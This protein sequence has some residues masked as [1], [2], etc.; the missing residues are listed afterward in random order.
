MTNTIKALIREHSIEYTRT[1]ELTRESLEAYASLKPSARSLLW[2]LLDKV[3]AGCDLESIVVNATYKDLSMDRNLFS[4]YRK[5]LVVAGFLQ[6]D[7]SDHY[8]NPNMINYH[9]RR[10]MDWLKSLFGL[11]KKP[12]VN[13]GDK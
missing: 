4:R 11:K 2:A 6:Y 3:N 8:I 12:E 9:N 5:E 13:F 7:L 10:Q 1:Y